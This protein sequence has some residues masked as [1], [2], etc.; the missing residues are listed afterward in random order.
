VPIVEL[1]KLAQRRG[2]HGSSAPIR[3]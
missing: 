2:F 3:A 1:A